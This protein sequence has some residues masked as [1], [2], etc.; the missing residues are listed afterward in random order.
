M[1]D[2]EEGYFVLDGPRKMPI[3]AAECRLGGPRVLASKLGE[4][5]FV[6]EGIEGSVRR[7]LVN[8]RS[9]D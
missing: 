5:L 8:D 1:G 6:D 4:Y 7:N 2:R 3:E 9:Q